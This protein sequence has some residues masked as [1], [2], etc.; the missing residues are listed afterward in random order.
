MEFRELVLGMVWSV[1]QSRPRAD[2][3]FNVHMASL[4]ESCNYPNMH[5]W[6]PYLCMFMFYVCRSRAMATFGGAVG[7]MHTQHARQTNVRIESTHQTLHI[8]IPNCLTHGAQNAE[9]DV[10]TVEVGLLEPLCLC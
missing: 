2:W 7:K 3:C 4:D 9:S 8:V 5:V 1:N 10:R 6:F